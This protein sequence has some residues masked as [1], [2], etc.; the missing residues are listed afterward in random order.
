MTDITKIITF[1]KPPEFIYFPDLSDEEK[2]EFIEKNKRAFVLYRGTYVGSDDNKKWWKVDAH[3]TKESVAHRD[4]EFYNK[5]RLL[6][7][8]L[9]DK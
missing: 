8:E 4:S 5:Y 1:D 7:G 9:N 6:L 2:L 3:Y